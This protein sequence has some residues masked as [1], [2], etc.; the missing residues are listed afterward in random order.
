MVLDSVGISPTVLRRTENEASRIFGNAG[1]EVQWVNCQKRGESENCHHSLRPDEFML[2][3]VHHGTTRTDLVFGEAFIGEDGTGKYADV[4]F[5]RIQAACAPPELDTAQL[6]G[7]V[8][9]HEVGHLLLG[10]SAH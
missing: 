7:A 9:A 2:H 4:F 3:I 5:D 10:S 6:L 8:V 1:V